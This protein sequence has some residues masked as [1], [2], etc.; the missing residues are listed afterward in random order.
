MTPFP[1]TLTR[2]ITWFDLETTGVDTRT[3]RI[4]EI[5]VTQLHPDGKR[6]NYHTLVNP[7]R[8]IPKGASD[9]HGITD[10]MVVGKPRFE[11]LAPRLINAFTNCDFGGYNVKRFDIEVMEAEFRRA[12]IEWTGEGYVIDGFKLW[13]TLF[14]RTL[15][16]YVREYLGREASDA[17]RATGDATDALEAFVAFYERHKD[18]LPTTLK[19]LHEFQFPVNPNQVDRKGNFVRNDHGV[20]CLSFG[21]HQGV[22]VRSVPSSYLDWWLGQDNRT[23]EERTIVAQIRVG[24]L[25]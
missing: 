5:G 16:D 3:D 11:D 22:P 17:H 25:Q 12:G 19:D 15:S 6:V 2:P 21:K 9:K 7:G 23:T 8:P 20:I 10:D 24:Q 1:F 4:V 14:P 18:K 13:Q